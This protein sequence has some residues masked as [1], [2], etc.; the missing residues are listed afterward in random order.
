MPG[1]LA[2]VA[3]ERLLEAY[4]PDHG[5][6]HYVVAP[7][8]EGYVDDVHHPDTDGDTLLHQALHKA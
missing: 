4:P 2:P 8:D 5:R 6:T 7:P 3:A 1:G